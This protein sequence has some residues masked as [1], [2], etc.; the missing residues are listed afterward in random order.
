[1][2]QCYNF[3][4][5]QTFTPSRLALIKTINEIIAEYIEQ[6]FRL[7]V[8]QNPNPPEW[9]NLLPV[10]AVLL[11]VSLEQYEHPIIAVLVAFAMFGIYGIY[12]ILRSRNQ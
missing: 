9:W 7:T 6:G 2:K 11:F 3:E 12:G 10:I 8:R 1:M 4:L 5:A